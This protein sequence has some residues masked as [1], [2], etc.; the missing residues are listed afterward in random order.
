M[1]TRRIDAHQHFWRL[2]RRDYG[3]LTPELTVLYR[4]FGPDDLAPILAT[5]GIAA[6]ILVQAAP[7]EAE[8]RFMRFLARET[9][10]IAGI[11]GWIDMAAHDA[12]ERIQV[13][14]ADPKVRGIRPMIHD[15]PDPDWM[16]GPGLAPAY[17]SVLEAGFTFDALLRPVHLPRLRTLLERYPE[18]PTVIDHG[19]KPDIGHWQPGDARFRAWA[20]HMTALGSDSPAYCKISGLVTEAR[21]EWRPD[22]LRPYLDHLLEA[23]GW[24]R[25][26]WGSDWPVVDR[27]GGYARWHGAA[28]A[29]AA[30]FPPEDQAKLFGGNAAR[31][32]GV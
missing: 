27:A 24:D 8:T 28:S 13:L 30:Q 11:V 5:T 6:T 1:T 29:W 2:D 4:D 32:Y 12:P 7:T 26:I 17:R 23:F 21:P 20:G 25:L 19:A 9:P 10:F 14:K 16:L 15:I 3:W 22:E 18:L 31:F